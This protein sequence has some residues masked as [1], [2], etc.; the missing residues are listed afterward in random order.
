MSQY[1]LKNKIGNEMIVSELLAPNSIVIIGASNDVEKPGGKILRNIIDGGFRG[2]L[3]AVNPKE[4]IVQGVRCFKDVKDIE[5]VELAILAIP[6]KFCLQA[7]EVLAK[8]KGTKAFIILSAGFSEFGES[9]RI[10]EQQIVEVV[11]SVGG[12]LI[13]PNCI[14]VM[15]QH[16]KGVFAGLVPNLNSKGCDMVSASGA[17]IAFILE[18]AVP[19]GLMFNSILSVGNSA[20]I[21]VE[22]VLEYWDETY[23]EKTSAKV[24]LFYLEQI[25]KPQKL[26]RH[27]RS[28]IMKGCRIAAIK[29]GTTEAGSRAVS[30]HTGALAGSD[31]AVDALFRKAGVVRCYSRQELVYVGGVLLHKQL[32]GPNIAVITHAGGS[33]VM[34]TDTLS[35]GG[36]NIPKIEGPAAEEL[37]AHLYYGASVSNPIDFL[38]TGTADQ[39]GTILEYVDREF[40]HIDGS[41]VIF[42]TTGMFDV[43]G[44]YDV[45]HEKMKWCKKPIYPCLPSVV[46]A[47]KAVKHFLSLGRVDFTD[48]VALGS[49]LSK[50]YHTPEPAKEFQLPE[51]DTVPIR[52][53]ID[54]SEE[55]YLS[56]DKIQKLLD[57]AGIPRVPERLADSSDEAVRAAEELGY[58]VV[59]KV[60]GPVHKTDVGGV[61]LN[62]RHPDIIRKEFARMLEIKDCTGVL[63]QPMFNGTELF[64]G[65]KKDSDF[66]HIILLG[67]G[68]IFIEVLKDVASGLAPLS[69]EEA[70]KMMSEL[71]SAKLIEGVRK[72]ERVNKEIWANIIERLSALLNAA[73]EITELDLNPL[74]GKSDSV[75]AVDG[76][77]RIEK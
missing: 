20:Q 2:K 51:I 68:G 75:I 25:K 4:D 43:T 17:T 55:G 5:N 31:A 23:D 3:S 16:Y 41:V 35:K 42:G 59:M 74:L 44:V 45:L 12:T 33:G 64:V 58:P 72:R 9:G 69:R 56:P 48:E 66:G 1:Y 18:M 57:A 29:A 13:G 39:L 14:G 30:S 24:K 73:P 34:L 37:L 6:P 54:A 49:A 28:L 27:C 71:K 60:V 11:E 50:V 22:E 62:I 21:G 53:I 77:I 8:E 40:H 46:Q 36:L 70:L 67:L 32:E 61:V 47:E 19:R 10:L 63:L 52:Q 76:R 15:T 7:V 26:L 65:A 38:A